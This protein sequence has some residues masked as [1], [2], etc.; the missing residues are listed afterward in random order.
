MVLYP[1]KTCTITFNPNGGVG[2]TK[3]INGY[4]EVPLSKQAVS[5]E[6]YTRTYYTFT[7][8]N[9]ATNG[10]GTTVTDDFVPTSSNNTVYAQWTP[11]TY[12]ITFDAQGG[13]T[14]LNSLP[15]IYGSDD[16]NK[17]DPGL[18]PTK[19]GYTFEGWF[20]APTG[21]N[22]V[23]KM[24]NGSCMKGA[25]W[26]NPWDV[27]GTGATWQYTNN[28]TLYAHWTPNT[29]T[30]NFNANGGTINSGNVTSYTYGT[31]TTLPGNVTKTG[32]TFGGWYENS[33]F[34]GSAVI[35]IGTT[36]I[37][38]LLELSS[39]SHDPSPPIPCRILYENVRR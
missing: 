5:F 17:L 7:G 4:Q 16:N 11:N 15:V 12:T 38:W 13:T 20:D 18:N 19:V 9:T 22:Q 3:T 32:Y 26:T 39:N 2:E 35:S 6:A 37:P 27:N 28:V 23:Y 25:Y 31:T 1:L 30:V 24:S 8:W 33:D 21:G 34:S 10:T 14:T 29:Y 36:A